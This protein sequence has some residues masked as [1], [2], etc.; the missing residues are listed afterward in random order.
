M[1]KKL[2]LNKIAEKIRKSFKDDQRSAQVF[3]TGSDII[4][5][6][7]PE[8]FV[9]LDPWFKEATGVMGLPF[10]YVFMIAGNT[11]SGKCL[12]KDTPVL[13]YNGTIKMVQDV[14]VG[15][16][17]MGPDSKP[18]T[19]GALGRGQEMMY[20]IIPNYGNLEWSCNESHILNL[21]HTRTGEV[22]NLS[23]SEYLNSN[24]TT[25]HNL[26]LHR[27]EVEF[28]DK[29]VEYDPY[30]VG[31]W[32]GDGT[33]TKTQITNNE[34]ELDKYYQEFANKNNL[35]YRKVQHQEVVNA[36]AKCPQHE[37]VTST[38][39]GSSR[40]N[41]LLNFVRNE[42][43]KNGEKYIPTNYLVNSREKRL[44]LLAGL[45]DTD[46]YLNATG[47]SCYEIIQKSES[48]ADQIV[49][50]AGSLGFRV[51]KTKKIGTIK[52]TGFSGK[53]YRISISGNTNVI[54]CRVQ[55][56]KALPFNGNR[57]PL[58]TGF[59]IESLGVGDYYGFTL[60]EDPLFL[61][62]DFTVTHNTSFAIE[63]IKNAQAQGVHVILVDTEKKTTGARL[64]SR[65]VDPEQIA[66]IRPDYLEDAY[67]GID[68]YIEYIKEADPDGRIL[69]VFDS[70]GNTPARAEADTDV[71]D[72]LQMGLAAKV[73]KRGFRRLVPK[74][75]KDKIHILVI[76]Q[77][78]ANMGSPGRTNAGGN[79]VDFF[80]ALTFQT[81]RFKWL[82]K[83]VK[84][85]QVRIGARVQWTLY[86]S[87]LFDGANLHKKI[88]IDITKDG[89]KL[90]GE[91]SGESEE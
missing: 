12:A 31:L 83:T 65:G 16:Q 24:I 21:K 53:Y 40:L 43:V 54:P 5:P 50:L 39:S 48:L 44:L 10:G 41:P 42:L 79:A 1:T 71:D 58:T 29:P 14:Q 60:V 80:S 57:N 85:E 74:L 88:Q 82:E 51:T 56:K 55:R 13:M 15:D 2:D 6:S 19:V 70:L 68:K 69:V 35:I 59:K 18:R 64:T 7:K 32:L 67:D 25:R 46:G 30:W 78:Y 90:V 63:A 45:L 26:K 77:T 66:L 72:S 9:V 11:D 38:G 89:M 20:K 34:P 37:F 33:R 4:T 3:G 47:K 23:V 49:F 36:A 81:S 17:L 22:V 27:T 91:P 84:G 28:T 8:D 61:L 75:N 62:G 76:N 52:S 73:N 86:K 87:H